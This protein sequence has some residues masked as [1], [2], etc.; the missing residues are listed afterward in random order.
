MAEN[1]T[2]PTNSIG[3]R[4]AMPD[5]AAHVRLTH[6]RLGPST[7]DNSAQLTRDHP[8]AARVPAARLL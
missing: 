3:P 1:K 7:P 6:P 4:F 2:Q 5:L 8:A